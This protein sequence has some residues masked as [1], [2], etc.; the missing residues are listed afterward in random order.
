MVGWTVSYILTSQSESDFFIWRKMDHA[1]RTHNHVSALCNPKGI[2]GCGSVDTC[3][4]SDDTIEEI[5]TPLER[6]PLIVGVAR[7]G[8]LIGLDFAGVYFAASRHEA[9]G[10]AVIGLEVLV[11]IATYLPLRRGSPIATHSALHGMQYR[12]GLPRRPR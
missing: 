8:L 4:E 7:L 12:S 11:A 6:F 1:R 2:Y 5:L 3:R 10:L 9:L